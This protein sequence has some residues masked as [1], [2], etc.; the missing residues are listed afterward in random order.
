MPTRKQRRR[1]QKERRHEYETVWVDAEGH[2]L[3]EPPDEVAAPTRERRDNGKPKPRTQQQRQRG[4]RS[5]RVPPPP[6]WQRA[7]RRSLILGVVVFVLFYAIGAKNGHH[8]FF[9]AAAIAVIY[10]GLFI[11]FTFMIDRWTHNRWQRR[12]EQQAGKT[13]AKRH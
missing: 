8:N 9:S 3:E 10:T 6:S 12:T 2:E 5:G 1:T 4:G 7:T 11:P 13:A